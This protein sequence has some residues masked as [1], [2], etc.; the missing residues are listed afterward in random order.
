VNEL[1][2]TKI[3]GNGGCE[4]IWQYDSESAREGIDGEEGN[5]KREMKIETGKS[6]MIPPYGTG[7][8]VW[9]IG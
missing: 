3:I 4:D 9:A 6:G 8:A 5:R 2:S 1:P 7:N